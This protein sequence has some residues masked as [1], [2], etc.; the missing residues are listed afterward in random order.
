MEEIKSLLKKLDESGKIELVNE[1]LFKLC[2]SYFKFVFND[3][4]ITC[5]MCDSEM[6]NCYLLWVDGDLVNFQICGD[7]LKENLKIENFDK[8][9]KEFI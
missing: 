7:C 8:F 3:H 1:S 5:D 6:G 2:G 9:S 4:G